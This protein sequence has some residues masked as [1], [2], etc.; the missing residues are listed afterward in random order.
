MKTEK[1]REKIELSFDAPT[2]RLMT[3]YELAKMGLESD[4]VKGHME[5]LLKRGFIIREEPAGTRGLKRITVSDP[6]N[7]GQVIFFEDEEALRSNK[8]ED[9]RIN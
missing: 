1:G 2:D 4:W 3:A 6:L 8:G 9:S 5:E 7:G